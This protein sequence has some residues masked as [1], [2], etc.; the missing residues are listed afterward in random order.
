M[1][2]ATRTTS[3]ATQDF[4]YSGTGDTVASDG[5]AS[6]SYD[7][8]GD[9]VA[10]QPDG[11]TAEAALTDLHDD[12]TGLFSPAASTT[13]LAASAAYS[14]YGTVTAST[15]TMPSLG[16]QGQYTDPSTGDTDMS[17]RWYSPSTGSFTSN[18]TISGS[19]V[20]TSVNP[21]PYGY[22]AGNPLTTTDPTGHCSGWFFCAVQ[23]AALGE[24]LTDPVCLPAFIGGYAWYGGGGGLAQCEE[25]SCAPPARA[26]ARPVAATCGAL[27]EAPGAAAA[28]RARVDLAAANLA[29]ADHAVSPAW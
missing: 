14:P 15:G 1:R 27:P 5:T 19:P 4:A 2:L 28:D 22:A 21:S 7:P 16:Y 18:D 25:I 26:G 23:D 12:V 8:A 11:G 20:A 9:L 3:S 10:S 24:C 29:A 6:Y 13:S 17:A